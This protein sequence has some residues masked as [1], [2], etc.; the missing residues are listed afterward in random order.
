MPGSLLSLEV[1]RR[2]RG[3]A[4]VEEG[5]GPLAEEWVGLFVSGG[6]AGTP[7]RGRRFVALRETG[8][9]QKG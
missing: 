9:E 5:H 7:Y 2:G 3:S 4:A 6:G 8:W 1:G